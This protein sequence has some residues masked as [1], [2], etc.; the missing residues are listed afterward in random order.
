MKKIVAIIS[1]GQDSISYL[2]Y[3]TLA[4]EDCE[5]Y[6]LSF[7]YGQRAN[8]EIIVAQDLLKRM[9]GQ[10]FKLKEH[11]IIDIS[12]MADLWKGS[13]LIDEKLTPEYK[14]RTVVPLRNAVFIVMASAYAYNIEADTILIGSHMDDAGILAET[15]GEFYYPDCSP[16]FTQTMELA[17]KFGH[18]RDA[19]RVIIMSPAR[20]GLGKGDLVSRG[21]AAIGDM[22]FDT[23][24]CY[25]NRKKTGE[26]YHCGV[27]KSCKDRYKAFMNI[28][29]R[30]QTKYL[31]E[32][33]K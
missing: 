22:V 18:F 2:A 15:G 6:A 28:I 33:S 19:K 7:N 5:V 27:C 20:E 3:K 12:F 17:M 31:T 13:Q 26:T 8:K 14:R 23:F 16:E 29:G 11:R 21:Y 4:I 1:G 30:D 25:A 9:D 32:M 10:Y 24:S